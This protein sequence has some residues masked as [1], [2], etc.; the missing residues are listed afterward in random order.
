MSE[1]TGFDTRG[2]ITLRHGNTSGDQK[3]LV[4]LLQLARQDDYMT[5]SS[6]NILHDRYSMCAVSHW[7]IE[8]LIASFHQLRER[9]TER[10]REQSMTGS[11]KGS[12]PHFVAGPKP[13]ARHPSRPVPSLGVKLGPF[14]P[15]AQIQ[16][17]GEEMCFYLAISPYEKSLCFHVEHGCRPSMNPTVP[18]R[19]RIVKSIGHWQQTSTWQMKLQSSRNCI[20]V[21]VG[22]TSSPP[23]GPN[24]QPEI[25][26]PLLCL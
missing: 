14:L 20:H 9:L 23:L 18:L 25:D 2:T 13:G 1:R 8:E 10:L 4:T 16:K 26:V 22:M 21:N 24:F 17:I 6:Y 15:H 7:E 5:D 19:L 3:V 11:S 12:L